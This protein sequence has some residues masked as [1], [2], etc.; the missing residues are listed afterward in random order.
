M[1]KFDGQGVID[2]TIRMIDGVK[3]LVRASTK[4][5]GLA[6]SEA[7]SANVAIK[8]L[9]V[10]LAPLN[11]KSRD[12]VMEA[13]MKSLAKQISNHVAYEA[14]DKKVKGIKT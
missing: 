12:I 4:R 3:R 1:E 11:G 14:I 7:A 8:I 13:M 10:I 6:V 5:K 9:A 2:E